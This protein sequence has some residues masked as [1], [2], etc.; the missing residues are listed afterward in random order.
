MSKLN[1]ISAVHFHLVANALAAYVSLSQ[2]G[3]TLEDLGLEEYYPHVTVTSALFHSTSD[4][5]DMAGRVLRATI[6][7][8]HLRLIS[9]Q[10]LLVILRDQLKEMR[11]A[12]K[13]VRLD[14]EPF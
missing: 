11:A 4:E 10:E 8:L 5:V 9:R 2:G 1:S 12:M 7:R 13:R 3:Y 14:V 6:D